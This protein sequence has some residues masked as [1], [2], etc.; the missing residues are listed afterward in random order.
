[1]SKLPRSLIIFLLVACFGTLF[2]GCGR[3]PETTD[4]SFEE[5]TFNDNDLQRVQE[6]VAS[7]SS[8]A[9]SSG[10]DLTVLGSSSSSIQTSFDLTIQGSQSSSST[11]SIATAAVT[12]SSSA[13]VPAINVVL[14]VEK[15]K[16]YDNLRMGIVDQAGNLYRVNN[17]FLNV[18]SSTQVG[19]TQ[20]EKLNQG[21]IV[22]VLDI[23]NAQWAKI[24]M[25][26]GKE[27][28]VAFRYIAKLTTEQ[29][30]PEDKKQFE[31]KYFVDFSFLNVR[32]DASAQAEKIGELP[33]QAIVKP[34][35]I[36]GEW[37]RVSIDGREGFVSSKYLK[38]FQPVYLVRQEDYTL[39]ILQYRATDN[40]S[41]SALGKHIAALKAAGMK[42]VTLD[43]LYDI[44]SDQEKRD[45]RITPGTVALTIAGVNG[46][47]AKEVNDTL[48]K[49]GVAATLF[50]TTKDVGITGVTEK[51]ML[52]LLANR[53]E[54]QSEGHTGDDLR[55]LTDAQLLLELGQSKKLIEDVTRREVYVVSYPQGGVNDRVMK[56]A[57]Q[58]G[59]LFGVSQAPDKKFTRS[60]FLRLPSLY[61]SSTMTPEEVVKMVK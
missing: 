56:V 50:I 45:A 17:P 49:A 58:A 32:K 22:T 41:L 16:Q 43:A 25:A 18:R 11:A 6:V 33:G 31:G 10:S 21:A 53:N 9:F 59:Y 48:Q 51:M 8:T 28:Y 15:Q 60:Q 5:F 37:A 40:G 36:N 19:S 7:S 34:L 12:T 46:K 14:D 27:G 38:P 61:V 2:M 26:D 20:V 39:P 57:S 42:V 23:P 35:S 55:S 3:Q 44:V 54:I 52:T 24:R 30:L 47:N 13:S 1:M 4:K 29:R